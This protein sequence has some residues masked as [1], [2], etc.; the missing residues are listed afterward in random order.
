MISFNVEG[1]WKQKPLVDE[2]LAENKA[3]ILL[4]QEIKTK[5]FTDEEATKLSSY[6]HVFNTEE[7]YLTNMSKKMRKCQKVS[8]WGTGISV[9]KREKKEYQFLSVYSKPAKC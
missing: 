1:Y 6:K 7:K 3:N 4:M 8:K 5:F 9:R 2:I